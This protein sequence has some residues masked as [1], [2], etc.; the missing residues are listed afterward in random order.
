MATDSSSGT[1]PSS[2]RLTIDSSSSIARSKL[3]FL[4][5]TWVFS[6][7]LLSR[8]R[9][10][11]GADLNEFMR[12][13]CGGNSRA[14]QCGD[15]GRDRLFQALQIIAALKHR[16]NSAT[17]ACIGDI[18][19][20]AATP[21]EIFR[22]EIERRQ[23]IS[24]MCIEAGGDDDQFGTEFPQ[25]RQD[26]VF[27][28]GA[29]F[30]AAVL[31]RQRRVDDGVVLAA[32]A[33]GAGAGKQRHLMRRAIHH[34]RIGPENILGAIAVMDVEIDHGGAGYAVFALGVT[35]GDRGMIEK[36]KAHRLAGLGMMAWRT[37]RDE[38]IMMGAC[39]DRVGGGNRAA[40]APHHR[41]PRAWRHRSVAVE[42]DQAAGRRDMPE[43]FDI[44]SVMAKRDQIKRALGS[45]FADKLAKAAFAENFIN[46]PNPIRSFGM[47]WRR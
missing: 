29:E 10:Y 31:R 43:F 41:L 24:I 19:Q 18:H 40:D 38:R 30:G 12:A 9:P 23:R 34:S 27:E 14:H 17:G 44:V 16:D 8:M 42:I 1:L 35:R 28:R 32:L 7:I 47:P 22:L 37:R 26:H 39:H 36:A 15:V 33:A 2:S 13:Y 21:A 6:A 11:S 20:L 5:S 46:G 3:S 45:L 25:L 4:T